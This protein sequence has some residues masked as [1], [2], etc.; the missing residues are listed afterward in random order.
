M[1]LPAPTPQ[2]IGNWLNVVHGWVNSICASLSQLRVASLEQLLVTEDQVA[3]AAQS[4]QMPA[5]AP[6]C[7]LTPREYRL[8]LP[9][10]ERPRQSEADWWERFLIASGA[11]P[12]AAR[13]LAAASIVG[14]V[15]WIGMSVGGATVYAYN[16]LALP[17][18]AQFGNRIYKLAPYAHE[19]IDIGTVDRVHVRTWAPN[20]AL[21]EEFDSSSP[22]NGARNVYNVGGASPL[23][24]WVAA[25]GTDKPSTPSVL[26][27]ARWSSTQADFVFTDPPRSVSSSTNHAMRSVLSALGGSPQ[28]M[29]GALSDP[30]QQ[31]D[32]IEVHARWD[33]GDAAYTAEWLQL[34]STLP[35]F[36]DIVRARL[37]RDPLDVHNLR[38]EQDAAPGSA[39]QTACNRQRQMAQV[40]PND[41]NLQYLVAR[42][43]D[44]VTEQNQRFRELQKQWPH[45]PWLTLGAAYAEAGDAHWREADKL[46][47]QVMAAL[48]ELRE[49]LIVEESRISRV[50][51]D[52]ERAYVTDSQ[53]SDILQVL[54][55]IEAQP[56][57][58]GGEIGAYASLARGN[59]EAA[60]RDRT[61]AP[62]NRAHLL[63]L[64]AASEGASKSVI[65]E[66]LTLPPAL[67]LDDDTLI[68]TLIIDEKSGQDSVSAT[69]RQS[70]VNI[71][72]QAQIVRAYELVRSHALPSAVDAAVSG[73]AP[74][75][76]GHIYAAAALLWGQQCPPQ[77]RR[78]ARELLFAT[79]RPFFARSP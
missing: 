63:R 69:E 32:L 45:N 28:R 10:N 35:T 11:W 73:M 3:H 21:I 2:N 1:K 22:G 50:L 20:G 56:P 71:P 77:W 59:I 34:A 29:L 16:G 70:A 31:R 33:A 4:G 27:S 5:S 36:A 57:P 7:S 52:D 53:Q 42:C 8:L 58:D 74:T 65:D 47:G 64:A 79:E 14:L 62:A 18:H 48:P 9:G 44:D 6:P 43:I 37:A 51:R 66:A 38:L 40:T 49:G 72:H 54:K 41:S 76:R 60:L 75:D 46:F 26:G 24:S 68:P 17:V 25:Y 15:V 55:T 13:V 12:A 19:S 78:L 61:L 23:L 30:A 39:H 67:G